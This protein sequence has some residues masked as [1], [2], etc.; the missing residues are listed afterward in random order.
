MSSTSSDLKTRLR[1]VY[2]SAKSRV[3]DA[4]PAGIDGWVKTNAL[5]DEMSMVL[6]TDM[7]NSAW[8]A[9]RSNPALLSEFE[10]AVGRWEKVHL[11]AIEKYRRAHGLVA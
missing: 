4:W 11:E 3:A 1:E 5:M 8:T 7:V 10:A 2:L 9:A 6:A